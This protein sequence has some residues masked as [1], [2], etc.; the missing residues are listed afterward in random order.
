MLK[1]AMYQLV[2]M[3]AS[4]T[5]SRRL[6]ISEMRQLTTRWGREDGGERDEIGKDTVYRDTLQT[7]TVS[8]YSLTMKL[9]TAG[10]ETT[11]DNYLEVPMSEKRE[12]PLHNNICKIAS[13]WEEKRRKTNTNMEG[14]CKERPGVEEAEGGRCDRLEQVM[15]T[16]TLQAD[17]V[18]EIGDRKRKRLTTL[19]ST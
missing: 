10:V 6:R 2:D 5:R 1:C 17:P 16:W 9:F 4:L 8:P 15:T 19:L 7:P 18:I 11:E 12:R 13:P 3:G 14:Q